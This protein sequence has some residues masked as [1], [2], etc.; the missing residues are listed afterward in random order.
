MISP[1]ILWG[2]CTSLGWPETKEKRV[3]VFSRLIVQV[4]ILAE[5][6]LFFPFKA[7]WGFQLRPP[8]PPPV[9]KLGLF[10]LGGIQILWLPT[11]V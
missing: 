10:H 2:K 8:T 4:V 1:I 9:L 5:L 7:E 6:I 3:P 11:L